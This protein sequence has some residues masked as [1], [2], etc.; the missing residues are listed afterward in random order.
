MSEQLTHHSG[1]DSTH[2]SLEKSGRPEVKDTDFVLTVTSEAQKIVDGV[3]AKIEGTT[4]ILYTPEGGEFS[5][6][7][8]AA[9]ANNE[10]SAV[11]RLEAIPGT[12]NI[13]ISIIDDDGKLIKIGLLSDL[14]NDPTL[15]TWTAGFHSDWPNR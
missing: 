13:G 2:A 1:E 7:N 6:I 3:K 9:I 15:S 4:L 10:D 5:R 12:G 11:M 8:L 14:E